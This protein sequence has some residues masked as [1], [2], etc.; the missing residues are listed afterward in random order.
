MLKMERTC[1][2]L[3]CDVRHKG[4]LI[5]RMEGVSITQWFIKNKYSYKGSFSNF[6]T[7]NP[8]YCHPG[9]IVDIIF[10][11]RNLIIKEARIGWIN[12]YGSNGTFQAAGIGY[13]EDY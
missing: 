11:D 3:R 5:G 8:D 13:Y 9:I 1:N 7:E 4:K 2:S 6:F 10:S 12:A